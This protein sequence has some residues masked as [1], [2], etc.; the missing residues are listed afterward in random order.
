M[1]EFLAEKEQPLH[2]DGLDGIKKRRVLRVL[3][4]N[5]AASYFLYKGELHGFE[6]DLAK[7]F[8]EANLKMLGE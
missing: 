1:V 7:A 2:T 3:L 4:R 5:N 6:Y 8:A